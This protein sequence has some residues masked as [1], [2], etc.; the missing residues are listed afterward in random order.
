MPR[1]SQRTLCSGIHEPATPRNGSIVVHQQHTDVVVVVVVA[2]AVS[3][4]G[5]I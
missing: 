4:R 3:E 2:A 1:H 5:E